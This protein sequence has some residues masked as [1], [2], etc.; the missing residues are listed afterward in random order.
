MTNEVR[1]LARKI[2]EYNFMRQPLQKSDC[3]LVLCSHD[4]RIA[5]HAAKLFLDGWAPWLAFSGGL[6]GF[7]AKIYDRAEAEVFA[8]RAIAAGVPS[9]KVLIESK[10]TNTGENLRNSDNLFKQRGLDFNAFIL[11]QKPNMLRRVFATAMKQWPG[12]KFCMSSHDIAFE[13]ASHRH[14]TEEM[15]IH[16][17]VGDLQRI[18]I[19]PDIGHQIIQ[20]IPDDVWDAYQ[21]LIQMGFTGN[22]VK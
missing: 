1:A 15:F 2:W 21:K 16:E 22:L 17:I 4:I 3:I 13:S 9:E 5:D 12:K 6:S 20:P 8:N 18:K 19:Y 11:V 7:T 14:V 10:S